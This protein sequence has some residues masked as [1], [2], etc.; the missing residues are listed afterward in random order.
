MKHKIKWSMNIDNNLG[1][2][3]YL[4]VFKMYTANCHQITPD[5]LYITENDQYSRAAFGFLFNLSHVFSGTA[6]G[7]G[8]SVDFKIFLTFAI[9]LK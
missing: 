8:V 2:F 5:L 7:F 1:F 4:S 6:H 3:H 9:K